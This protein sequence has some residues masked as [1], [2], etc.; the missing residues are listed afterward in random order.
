MFNRHLNK[1]LYLTGILIWS[2]TCAAA[3]DGDRLYHQNCVACHGEGGEG[4]VGVPLNLPDFLAVAS[5]DYL[6]ATIRNGRP[7]RVMPAFP[8]L[9]D[10]EL[11]AIVAYLRG[12]SGQAAPVYGKQTIKGDAG[13]G[14]TL[15]ASHCSVC[16]GERGQGGTGTGVTFSRPR[17]A[18][19]MAPSLNNRGFQAAVSDDM[20]KATLLRGR[21]GTPMPSITELG[22][23][24]SDADDLVAFLRTLQD[25]VR[26]EAPESPVIQYESSYDLETTLENLKQSVIGHNFRVIREQPLEQGLAEEGQEDRRAVI[27]YFCDFGFLNKALAIDPRVGLFLPCRVTLLETDHGVQVMSINPKNLSHLFNNRELDKACQRMHD[28]YGEIMEEAT[29]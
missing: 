20:L 15:F 29:F 16:H 4:G 2:A 25:E 7:G 26:E 13:R 21:H 3:P 22:L 11:D 23:E 9:A 27:L 10:A 19:V 1:L 5:D 12:F 18:P 24:A 14:K 6:R 28:L 17:G 8:R